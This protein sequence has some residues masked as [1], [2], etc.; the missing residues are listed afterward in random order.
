MIM[1]AKDLSLTIDYL[2]TRDDIDADKIAYYGVSWGA[3]MGAIMPSVEK[4]I[5]ASVL[6]VAG[7]YVQRSLPEVEQINFLPRIKTPVL[8]LNGEY[9]Y[10]FPYETSQV[11]FYTLLGTPKE[12]KEL[13]LYYGGHSMPLTQL[14]K[15][16]LAWLDRYLGPV[17]KSVE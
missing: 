17:T 9:D 14:A 7:L 8:M 1:W 2:E 11:P 12:H 13:M 15:E 6:C 5:K 10:W 16:T 3:S 4:R